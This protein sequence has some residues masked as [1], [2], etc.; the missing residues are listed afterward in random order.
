MNKLTIIGNLTRDPELRTTSTGVNV[1]SFT[2]A[3]NR[4]QRQGEARSVDGDVE[5][6]LSQYEIRKPIGIGR[7]FA[8]CAHEFGRSGERRGRSRKLFGARHGVFRRKDVEGE[9]PGDHAAARL[10]VQ[11]GEAVERVRLRRAERPR[12]T[13]R[14]GRPQAAP[15]EAPRKPSIEMNA[16]E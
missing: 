15:A 11:K 1:C 4:R 16:C 12:R 14:E 13:V 5:C 7:E 8:H 9:A 10:L 2:V 3:V 6:K